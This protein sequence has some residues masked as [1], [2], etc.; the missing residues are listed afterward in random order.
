MA[1]LGTMS[2]VV[3]RRENVISHERFCEMARK[4]NVRQRDLILEVLHRLI[5]GGPA[6][7]ILLTGPAGCGKTFVMR[8]IME[9]VNRL[10]KAP[11]MHLQCLRIVRVDGYGSGGSGWHDGPF[12]IPSAH[13]EQ[14]FRHVVRDATGV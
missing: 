2:S 13:I 1:V 12:S 10:S 3:R 7:K 9:T 11:T 6:L 5:D 14:G 8:L 4:T